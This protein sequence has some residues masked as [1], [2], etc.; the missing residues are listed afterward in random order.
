VSAFAWWILTG[1]RLPGPAPWP[2]PLLGSPDVAR[3]APR[4]KGSAHLK[5]TSQKM[6][7]KTSRIGGNL[8]FYLFWC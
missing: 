2:F 1:F 3:Q 4:L 8:I 7:K 6:K 5:A